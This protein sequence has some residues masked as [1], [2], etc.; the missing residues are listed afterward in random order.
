MV[1]APASRLIP[2]LLSVN[3]ALA[4][5]L[6]GNQEGFWKNA[7]WA[8]LCHCDMVASAFADNLPKLSVMSRFVENITE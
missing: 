4:V 3:L 6:R 7:V 2:W 1:R 8:L 5:L